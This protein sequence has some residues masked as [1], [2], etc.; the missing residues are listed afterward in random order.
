[1]AAIPSFFKAGAGAARTGFWERVEGFLVVERSADGTARRPIF[2]Y[3]VYFFPWAL[4]QRGR[5]PIGLTINLFVELIAEV[6][7]RVCTF[8][9]TLMKFE[10]SSGALPQYHVK[11]PQ[12]SLQKLLYT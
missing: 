5:I 3:E 9:L 8:R 2:G 7:H 4:E 11:C 12:F 10:H 1:M 6:R